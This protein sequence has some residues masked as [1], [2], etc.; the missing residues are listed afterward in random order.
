MVSTYPFKAVMILGLG[1]IFLSGLLAIQ[2]A[3][4]HGRKAGILTAATIS[5]AM[6]VYEVFLFNMAFKWVR[7]FPATVIV[8][9]G[10]IAA[11]GII[12]LKNR[13]NAG[14]QL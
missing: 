8:I 13:M 6:F 7:Y 3:L 10:W 11:I 4:K 14:G 2:T 1:D 9:I 12:R 5:V